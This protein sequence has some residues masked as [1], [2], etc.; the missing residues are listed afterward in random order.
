MLQALPSAQLTHEFRSITPA[1]A[2]EM[3]RADGR[4]RPANDSRVTQMQADMANG[5]WRVNGEA[6]VFD[7]GGALID[8]RKRLLACVRAGKA[9]TSL[10]VMGVD[11][12][13][14][15]SVDSRK[16]RRLA[17]VLTI[18]GHERGRTMETTLRF[19]DCLADGTWKPRAAP[20]AH[21]L[22]AL[23]DQHPAISAS[24]ERVFRPGRNG[25]A[26]LHAAMHFI[27][28]RIDAAEAERFFNGVYA[29]DEHD[30]PA[31]DPRRA[32]SRRLQAL[33]E[34]SERISH[35][36]LAALFVVA[37]NLHVAGTKAMRIVVSDGDFPEIA[38]WTPSLAVR[39]SAA[40]QQLA[41]RRSG[42]RLRHV[43]VSVR[44]VD[45][46]LAEQWLEANTSN[47]RVS[48]GT[49]QRYARDMSTGSWQLNGETVKFG[50][51]G[52]LLDGQH[53]LKAVIESGMTVAMLVVE[54]LDEE[55]F[56]TIDTGERRQFSQKLAERGVRNY[57][58][59]AAALKI[60]LCVEM[61]R[62]LGSYLPTNAELEDAM[63]RHPGIVEASSDACVRP[64]D[65]GHATALSYLFTRSNPEKS[66]EFFRKLRGLGSFDERDPV[67]HLRN[68]LEDKRSGNMLGA[69]TPN[70]RLALAIT[71]WNA[72]LR[73][74][75]TAKLVLKPVEGR[76]FPAI[77]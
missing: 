4:Q 22:R 34:L 16:T 58:S 76:A 57:T 75:K 52:R 17:D 9:F 39:V 12:E 48:P 1:A 71:A 67:L 38:F 25:P 68:R 13:S 69:D 66:A 24:L 65:P 6:I 11:P 47:R 74:K 56:D 28:S 54:G 70:T 59:V 77:A 53:R 18:D 14:T 63:Q 30:V 26:T 62:P 2:E 45:P 46:D 5:S 29:P 36:D 8:G 51:R 19:V 21:E 37:W 15:L 50:R 72:F 42:G 27:L 61:D 3:L 33:T 49:M 40:P 10:V 23:L 43:D 64:L 20:P 55:V 60:V 44:H 7:T 32:L 73:G 35:R 31:R 41:A